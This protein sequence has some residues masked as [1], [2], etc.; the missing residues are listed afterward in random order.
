MEIVCNTASLFDEIML[1]DFFFINCKCRHCIDAKGDRSW[2]DYRVDL[3]TKVS[4]ELVK[5]VR[6]VNPNCRVIIKFPNWFGSY[7]YSGYVPEIQQ[8]IFDEVFIGNETR[9]QRYVSPA[10]QRYTSYS[11]ARLMRNTVQEKLTGGWIDQGE[12]T[13]EINIWLQ[14][15]QLALFAKL[16]ELM[17]FSFDVLVDNV[18]LPATGFELKCIDK[19]LCQLGNPVGVSVYLPY[20]TGSETEFFNHLGMLGIP[21]EPSPVFRSDKHLV[22]VSANAS[23][24]KGIIDKIRAYVK[25]GGRVIITTEFVRQT[26]D[27]GIQELISVTTSERRVSGREY[28]IDDYYVNNM[29]FHSGTDAITMPIMEAKA[30]NAWSTIALIAH[31]NKYPLLVHEFYGDGSIFVLNPPDDFSDLYRL[32][33]AVSGQLSRIFAVEYDIFLNSAGKCNLFLYDNDIFGIYTYRPY[34]ED[35]EVIVRSSRY[36]A[37]QNLETGEVYPI[38]VPV[39]GFTRRFEQ[40]ADDEITVPEYVVKLPQNAGVYLKSGP[41]AF[42]KLLPK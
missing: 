36:K 41:Y 24:E 30:N 14:Q 11:I 42:Y 40:S 15:A 39:K 8:G 19:L 38:M 17:M 21:M 13:D 12:D 10:H 34:P 32:P 4:R 31:Q 1:D 7:L 9:A 28:I 35:M 33:K 22:F 25:D 26:W 37:V 23:Q 29:E 16:P 6:E 27:Q 20:N 2:K 5:Q 3:M 18:D